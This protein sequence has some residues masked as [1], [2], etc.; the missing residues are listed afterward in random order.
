MPD[1]VDRIL[2]QWASQRPDLDASPMA[3]LG[4]ILRVARELDLPL[5]QVFRRFGLGP[6]EF[7][8]LA[9]LRR[10]GDPYRLTPGALVESMMVSSGAVT[11]RVDRLERPGLVARA[12]DPRDRRGVLVGL[13][14]EGLTLVDHA[15]E[16]H[17]ANEE[18]LLARLT[19]KEREQLAHLLRKLGDSVRS[20][21]QRQAAEPPPP[22]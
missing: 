19:Q 1:A 3:V 8:V 16:A 20:A 21:E 4:R 6:G 10:A 11:K 5:Q 17:L 2:E 12:P 18:R 9:T 22:G 14:P 7:D 15:V 13:T